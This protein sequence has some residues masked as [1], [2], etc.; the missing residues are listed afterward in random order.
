M[1]HDAFTLGL[2]GMGAVGFGDS[3]TPYTVGRSNVMTC[4]GHKSET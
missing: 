4:F 3:P 2:L 1:L